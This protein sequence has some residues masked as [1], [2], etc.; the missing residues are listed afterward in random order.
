MTTIESQH[1]DWER[2]DVFAVVRNGVI[3]KVLS[4]EAEASI[5]AQ[6]TRRNWSNLGRAVRVQGIHLARC[7]AYYLSSCVPVALAEYQ[8]DADWFDMREEEHRKERTPMAWHSGGDQ[9]AS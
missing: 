8:T 7:Q 5:I 9:C 2:I 1:P 3:I 4:S 6:E